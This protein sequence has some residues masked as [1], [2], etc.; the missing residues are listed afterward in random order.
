MV[1]GHLYHIPNAIHQLKINPIYQSIQSK[2][3]S[4]FKITSTVTRDNKTHDQLHDKLI[5]YINQI[6][7]LFQDK[8][9]ES[10]R[11]LYSVM[12]RKCYQ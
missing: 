1:E 7:W 12:I 2:L 9:S 4:K 5:E 6:F 11:Y 3:F 10:V 8:R